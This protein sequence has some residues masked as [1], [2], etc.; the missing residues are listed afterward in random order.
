M[1]VYRL[2]LDFNI[3][4]WAFGSFPTVITLWVCMTFSTVLIVYPLF[5][6][7]AYNRRPGKPGKHCISGVVIT[8]L[9]TI[10]IS[11]KSFLF[12]AS[13]SFILHGS[14]ISS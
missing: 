4:M 5:Q 6:Y 1:F 2:V 9:P 10:P 7:W 12:L 3:I 8:H 13:D 11:E 14:S